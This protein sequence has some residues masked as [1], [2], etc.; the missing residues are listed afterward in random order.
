MEISYSKDKSLIT[1]VIDGEITVNDM[2]HL[3]EVRDQ[4]SSNPTLSVL[5]IVTSFKGYQSFGAMKKALLGD[6]RMLPKLTKYAIV[7]DIS[8]LRTVVSLLNYLV[9]KS[10]LKAFCPSDH[11][12]AVEWLEL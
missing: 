2:L 6:L 11:E 9:L 5:A 1:Y 7:T 4:L 8:W 12:L 10:E 3:Q